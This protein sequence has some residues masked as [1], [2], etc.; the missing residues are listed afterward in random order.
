MNLL[1][2]TATGTEHIAADDIETITGTTP[3]QVAPGRLMLDA[4]EDAV[5]QLNYRSGTCTRIIH[6]LHSFTLE[7]PADAYDALAHPFTEVMDPDQTF[8]VRV[9]RRGDH[10]F[11]STDIAREAGQAIVE[12]IEDTTGTTPSVD[13]D[14]PD[15]VFRLDLYE[16]QA[17]FGVDT[18]GDSLEDR[19]YLDRRT[20][21]TTSPVL[22]QH[23][24]RHSDWS[25]EDRLLDPFCRA[26]VVAIEAG[27]I[28]CSIPNAGRQFA[29]LE[30]NQFDRASY[31]KVAQAAKQDMAIT[32]VSIEASDLDVEGAESHAKEAG[33]DIPVTE[34]D[35]R[36]RPLTGDVLLFHAPFQ[37]QRSKRDQLQTLVRAVED[38]M[39][40]SDIRHAAALTQ[41]K[42]M[43]QHYDEATSIGLDQFDGS[44]ITWS[45]E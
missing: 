29:F 38:R 27:R 9:E 26:G 35:P 11:T 3:E 12:Q 25:P 19:H 20:E 36:D 22:A 14:A 10:D 43:F 15:V 32:D 31:G 41:D 18:T 21:R 24:I 28:Q 5:Y 39:L 1:I 16:D 23:L 6:L 44:I 2:W 45:C 34:R 17:Y 42:S 8:A 4:D 37:E 33:L 13:L 30:L 7:E 40:E